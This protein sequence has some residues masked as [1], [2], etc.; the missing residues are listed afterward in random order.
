MNLNPS[1]CKNLT[2]EQAA[3]NTFTV[4][5]DA[6]PDATDFGGLSNIPPVRNAPIQY[7]AVDFQDLQY[8]QDP[9]NTCQ[10]FLS[11]MMQGSPSL[12][13]I[14]NLGQL[15]PAYH[16]RQACYLSANNLQP[17]AVK[18]QR[19]DI[20]CRRRVRQSSLWRRPTLSRRPS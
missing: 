16:G 12:Q 5:F 17:I 15:R 11:S 18:H 13:D 1:D 8:A 7:V 9:A 10:T 20:P 4:F 2:P 14:Y 19:R 6:T 3:Y